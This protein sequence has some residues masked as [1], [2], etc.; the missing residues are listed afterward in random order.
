MVCFL[1]DPVPKLIEVGVVSFVLQVTSE[2]A[3]QEALGVA[4]EKYGGV[5]TVVNCAGVGVAMR[6]VSKRGPHP[7]DQFQRV[8]N[9]N[10]VGT[11]NVIRLA[12]EQMARA[13]PYSSSGER[14]VCTIL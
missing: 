9:V 6:T 7:L 5:T 10:V 1:D 2:S 14:G 13:D 11:F 8:I 3:V 12:A 4:K